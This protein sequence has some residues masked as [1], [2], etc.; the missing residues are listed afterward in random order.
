MPTAAQSI[1]I[2]APVERVF[3]VVTDF[4]S[5][6]KFL[7]DMEEVE[8]LESGERS[9]KVSFTTRLIKRVN[10]ILAF[11]LKR[12]RGATWKLAGGDGVVKK[13]TGAWRFKKLG[14]NLTE[15]EFSA[16]MELG[17]WMPSSVVGALISSHL[18]SM[19]ECFKKRAERKTVKRTTKKS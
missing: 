11:D 5:Y 19:L 14:A 10:Y 18:P 6:P 12:P 13:N 7:P 8:V 16:D 3:D 17:I 2:K 1:E 9:A 4:A 15:L